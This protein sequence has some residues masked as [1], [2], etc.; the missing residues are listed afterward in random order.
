MMDKV[1]YMTVFNIVLY[2]RLKVNLF[3]TKPPFCICENKGA[4]QKRAY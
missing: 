4:D 1:N 2:L 3:L